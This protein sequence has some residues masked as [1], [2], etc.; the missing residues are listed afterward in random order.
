MVVPKLKEGLGSTCDI[1]KNVMNVVQEYK[2]K[3]INLDCSLLEKYED[4]AHYYLKD[5]KDEF[6]KK[7]MQEKSIDPDDPCGSNAFEL[8]VEAIHDMYPHKLES[9]KSILNRVDKC[10]KLVASYTLEEQSKLVVV[11][12]SNFFKAWTGKWDKP[13]EEY[14]DLPFPKEFYSFTNCEIY[15]DNEN[16]PRKSA[17]KGARYIGTAS[18]ESVVPVKS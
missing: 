1:P 18:L 15:P 3:F 7:I 11:A 13:L 10:K 2:N 17:Q 6:A 8:L 9:M 5:I 14:T 16:F 12:H 4:V